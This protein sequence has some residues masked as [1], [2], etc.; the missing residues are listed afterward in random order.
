MLSAAFCHA[1]VQMC[2]RSYKITSCLLQFDDMSIADHLSTVACYQNDVASLP[3]ELIQMLSSK[4]CFKVDSI[5]PLFCMSTPTRPYTYSTFTSSADV[6]MR[7][8]VCSSTCVVTARPTLPLLEDSPTTSSAT[9]TNLTNPFSCKFVTRLVSLCDCL[10][11]LALTVSCVLFFWLTIGH[12]TNR[13]E[14]VN[15]PSSWDPTKK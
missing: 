3:G 7:V 12:V 14:M 9:V 11:R 15:P 4:K 5:L 2:L 10:F 6:A 13:R 8:R 1:V